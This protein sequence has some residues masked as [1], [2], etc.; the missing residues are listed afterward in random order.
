[1]TQGYRVVPVGQALANKVRATLKAPGYGHPATVEM[2][3]GYGPCRVCL[4]TFAVGEE[5]R[6]LFTYDPFYG[7][8]PFPLPSPIY[9]HADACAPY[10]DEARFPDGLRFIPLTLNAYGPDATLLA[11]ERL[12]DGWDDRVEQ[13]V[14]RLFRDPVVEYIHVRNTEA[15][16]FIAHLARV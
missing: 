7:H 4:Q 11:Q 8:A 2:A 14:D 3:A 13:S 6:I 12:A 5:R 16:C 10:A 1:M 9:V 15:G